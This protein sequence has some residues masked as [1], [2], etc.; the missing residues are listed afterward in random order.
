M[1]NEYGFEHTNKTM[2]NEWEC[3]ED[4]S[5]AFTIAQLRGRAS[6]KLG[7]AGSAAAFTGKHH[8]DMQG[9]V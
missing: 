4:V 7:W 9:G 5:G 6:Q 2:L 3:E 1:V 8:W